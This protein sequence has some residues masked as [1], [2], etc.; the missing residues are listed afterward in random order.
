MLCLFTLV[1]GVHFCI[2]FCGNKYEA[3]IAVYFPSRRTPAGSSV[4]ESYLGTSPQLPAL[5]LSQLRSGGEVFHFPSQRPLQSGRI[6]QWL[7]GVE[8]QEE[9]PAG[10]DHELFV[11][12]R[13]TYFNRESGCWEALPTFIQYENKNPL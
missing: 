8:R 7:Q 5:V 13:R 3:D 11:I 1:F 12:Q 9:E 10:R 2:I 4:L 6:L